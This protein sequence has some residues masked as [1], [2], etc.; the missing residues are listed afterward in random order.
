MA[1]GD[2]KRTAETL[3]RLHGEDAEARA[4][5]ML[6]FCKANGNRVGARV[7]QRVLISLAE[8]RKTPPAK[9]VH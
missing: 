1:E 6:A 4:Q 8:L 9:R 5:E 3:I 2:A 7:W